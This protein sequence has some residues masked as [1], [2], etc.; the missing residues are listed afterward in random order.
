[1]SITFRVHTSILYVF[2][3]AYFSSITNLY[4]L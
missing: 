3:D 1:M 2:D 4:S